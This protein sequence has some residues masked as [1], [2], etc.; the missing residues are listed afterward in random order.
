MDAVAEITSNGGTAED[1]PA[2]MACFTKNHFVEYK[3]DDKGNIKPISAFNLNENSDVIDEELDNIYKLYVDRIPKTAGLLIEEGRARKQRGGSN[4]GELRGGGA[5]A[6]GQAASIPVGQQ[7]DETGGA[8]VLGEAA[9]GGVT[10]F[11]IVKD[12]AEIERLEN[13]PT[14]KV[15]R[16]RN[17]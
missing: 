13:E 12:K 5:G 11:H 4:S 16:A 15:Y 2:V 7:S 1:L 17:G 9:D 10:E 6:E 8:G 3:I 14:I